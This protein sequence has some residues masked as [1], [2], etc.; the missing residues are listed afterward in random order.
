MSESISISKRRITTLD[1]V[2]CALFTALIA[3]GAFIRIPIPVVPFTL[4]FLFTTLAGLILGPRLGAISCALYV[5]LGLVGLPIFAEGGGIWYV[6]KPSFGYL[7]GFILGAYITGRIAE[8]MTNDNFKGF[9]VAN[10]AGLA[11]VYAMGM[12]YYYAICN[13]VIDTPIAFWP[14]F[15]YCFIMAVP[16]DIVI[17]FVTALLVKRLRAAYRSTNECVKRR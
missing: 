7:I 11:V 14:L 6:A 4:Q 15:L 17:C 8:K 10:F 2:V 12:A 3:V 1:M 13:F 9:L 16:G 5:A